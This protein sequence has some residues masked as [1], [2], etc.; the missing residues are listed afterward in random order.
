MIPIIVNGQIN[1]TKEDGKTNDAIYKLYHIHKLVKESIVE[2]TKSRTKY[3]KCS[4]L[5][6]LLMGDSHVRVGAA[7][8][9]ASLDA[10]FDVYGT[11]KPG[12]DTG[13]LTDT[14]KGDVEK[15]TMN[16]FLIICSGTNDIYR[17][18]LSKA[19]KNIINFIK[20]VNY[21]NIIIVNVP[22]RYDV[23]D[24]PYVNS[25][26]KAFNSKLQKLN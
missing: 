16:D 12:S 20:N 10:R 3:S 18:Y 9:S 7:N 24:Y 26:I 19:L 13:S 1:A 22:Y 15:L 17:N 21:T 8:L 25:M 23:E 5:K 2:V 6:V 11:V 4:K 14:T